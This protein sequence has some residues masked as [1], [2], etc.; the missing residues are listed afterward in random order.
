LPTKLGGQAVTVLLVVVALAAITLTLTTP[1]LPRTEAQTISPP[2]TVT[3]YVTRTVYVSA[4]RTIYVSR[5]LYASA[6]Q[7]IIVAQTQTVSVFQYAT[8]L[9]TQTLQPFTTILSTFTNASFTTVVTLTET[10]H[11]MVTKMATATAP[12]HIGP[13]SLDLADDGGLKFLAFTGAVALA[14]LI[15]GILVSRMLAH[16]KFI[17]PTDEK[18]FNPQPEPPGKEF[19]PQPEPPGRSEDHRLLKRFRKPRKK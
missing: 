14:G 16:P 10:S 17:E 9:S 4:V 3:V 18:E 5:T 11:S 15:V 13:F 1:S 7:T 6:A 8:V 2:R 12:F 19:N